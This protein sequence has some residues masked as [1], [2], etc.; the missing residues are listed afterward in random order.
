[1]IDDASESMVLHLYIAGMTAAAM[2]ARTNIL[3]ICEK[4]LPG[5]YSLEVID[6]VERPELA[7]GRQIIAVPTLVRKNPPLRKIVGD[8]SNSD[9]V[10]SGLEIVPRTA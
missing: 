2:H 9:K 4:H 3:G 8:L 5:R 10:M 6:L 1:M 7:E